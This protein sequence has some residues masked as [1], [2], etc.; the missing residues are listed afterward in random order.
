[1]QKKKTRKKEPR[2]INDRKQMIKVRE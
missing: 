2:E 1:M